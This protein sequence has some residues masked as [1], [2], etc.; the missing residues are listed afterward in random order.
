MKTL[1]LIKHG[2]SSW[3]LPDTRDIER[4]LS[5]SGVKDVETMSSYLKLKKI[6]ACIFL[7]SCALRAQDT[8]DILAQKLKFEG[9]RVYLQELY[10]TPA[11]NAKDILMA[12]SDDV[13]TIFLVGH[14][15]QISELVNMLSDEHVNKIPS[16]GIV[17]LKFDIDMWDDLEN[18]KG[19]IESFI[20]PKQF[21]YYMPR[22]MRKVLEED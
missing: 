7:S 18:A 20:I 19:S 21:Q 1:Y 13:D 2:K 5:K 9:K 15:P 8:T 3:T 16:M 10:M 11:E 22:K 12:Q 4:P 17:E 14:N 6:K